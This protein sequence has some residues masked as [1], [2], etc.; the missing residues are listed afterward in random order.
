LKTRFLLQGWA[1]WLLALLAV[2]LLPGSP[3]HSARPAPI[4]QDALAAS[5]L[6]MA[7]LALSAPLLARWLGPV[8]AQLRFLTLWE[9][10]PAFAWG[11][12]GLALWPAHWGPP[13]KIAWLLLFLLAALPSELRWLCQAMP[14][15][16]PFPAAWGT[17]VRARH[18]TW[19]LLRLAPR[20]LG[21]RVPLWLTAT[22]IL[23][24]ML[25]VPALGSDWMNRIAL[26]DRP[27]MAVWILVLALL[28]S[29]ARRNEAT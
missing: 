22:L 7:L 27:G 16:E 6:A 25:A 24:R 1:L 11:G 8:G 21:A 23:E 9:S 13:G 10:L 15:E 12:L 18:R 5:L 3:W 20:W 28:W 17:E 29:L 4:H 19:T 2:W 26:R 14:P